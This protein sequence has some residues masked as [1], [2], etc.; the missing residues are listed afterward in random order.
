MKLTETSVSEKMAAILNFSLCI[1]WT[2]SRN[3]ITKQSVKPA[4]LFSFLLTRKEW[5][6]KDDAGN[7]NNL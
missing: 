4:R 6:S 1:H 7:L 2:L 5:I 3:R